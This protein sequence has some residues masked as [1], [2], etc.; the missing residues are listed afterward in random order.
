[1][2][3]YIEKFFNKINKYNPND[4]YEAELILK[5]W[6]TYNPLEIKNNFKNFILH[7]IKSIIN[8]RIINKRNKIMQDERFKKVKLAFNCL[9]NNN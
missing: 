3:N 2:Y 8:Y 6:R 9:Y 5:I 7:P 1:M 4:P